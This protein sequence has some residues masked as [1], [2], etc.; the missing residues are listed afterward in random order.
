MTD[1]SVPA[2]LHTVQ[3]GIQVQVMDTLYGIAQDVNE[4]QVQ[5]HAMEV[6]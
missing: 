6:R 4:L 5:R 1:A 3:L 2:V